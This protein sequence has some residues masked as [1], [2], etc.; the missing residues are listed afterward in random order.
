MKLHRLPF[1]FLFLLFIT[2]ALGG[3]ALLK[4]SNSLPVKGH[5]SFPLLSRSECLQEYKAIPSLTTSVEAKGEITIEKK[6]KKVSFPVR[7]YLDPGK[8]LVLSVRPV[9][10][11]EVLRITVTDEE[12]FI[13][14]KVNK[15]YFLLDKDSPMK[16]MA[17]LLFPLGLDA[18]IA[19]ITN[20]PFGFNGVG[21]GV[22]HSFD[23]S[24]D[25]TTGYLFTQK[26]RFIKTEIRHQLSRNLTLTRSEIQ[27]P[28]F[29]LTLEREGFSKEYA[30]PFLTSVTIEK[31]KERLI[32]SVVLDD[33]RVKKMPPL[34]TP[35]TGYTRVDFSDIIEKLHQ[36]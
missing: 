14:D 16:Y 23:F 24:S 5:R 27:S 9:S 29:K 34:L 4:R 11:L 18:I 8:A 19:L 13:L 3:C 30:L 2:I 22:L 17:K 36:L 33:I 12:L 10:F 31:P 1:R 28:S 7:Y 32:F 21:K 35:P 26:N 20:E 15:Q 6:G 25:E